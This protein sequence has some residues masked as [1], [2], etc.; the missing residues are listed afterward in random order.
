MRKISFVFFVA[1]AALLLLFSCSSETSD[2][3]G[4]VEEDIVPRIPVSQPV[5]ILRPDS[6]DDETVKAAILIR[7][8]FTDKGIDIDLYTDFVKRGEEVP[9]ADHEIVVG[10]TNRSES[11]SNYE[12]LK[13]ARSCSDLDWSIIEKDGSVYITG[14]TG[15][16][17]YAA[18]EYFSNNYFNQNGLDMLSA[19]KY[20]YEY[21]YITV[22]DNPLCNFSVECSDEVLLGETRN[23]LINHVTDKAGVSLPDDSSSKIILKTD[24]SLEKDS[25]NITSSADSVILSG[26]SFES[27]KLAAYRFLE[28]LNDKGDIQAMNITEKNSFHIPM[29]SVPKAA[30]SYTSIGDPIYLIEDGKNVLSGWD[31]SFPEEYYENAASLSSSPSA[32]IRLTNENTGKKAWMERRFNAQNSGVITLEL[33][34]SFKQADGFIMELRDDSKCAVRFTVSHGV[35]FADSSEVC[36]VSP[37]LILRADF[38][39]DK[40][41][42]TV[43]INGDIIGTYDF[44]EKINT[45][46]SLYFELKET[47]S[48]VLTPDFIYLYKNVI[49]SERFRTTVAGKAPVYYK[50]AGD[51]AVA[52]DHDVK[53]GAS[54]SLTKEFT[55]FNGKAVFQTKLLA[56]DTL[57]KTKLT[58]F[59]G[60]KAV[61]TLD[62]AA[63]KVFH[64]DD[65]L[66][67]FD[68]CFWYTVRIEP[69]TRNCFAEVKINGKSLGYFVFDEKA[70]NYDS[71]AVSTGE[72]DCVLVDDM[73]IYQLNEYDD[74]VPAPLS[75]GSG[76]S[77]V[78]CQVCSLWRNGYHWAWDCIT[79]YNELKPVLG[80]YDEGIVEVADWE[81]KY[82][83]EHG[84]DYQLYCWYNTSVSAPIKTCNMDQALHDGYFNAK[85]SDKI[86]FAIMW[87]NANATHP[88]S[89]ENFRN[90]IV[91][92]WVEY[93]LTDPRYITI[94]NKPVIT[95]FSYND[96]LKDFGSAEGVK[97]EFD[98]LRDVCRGLGYDGAIIMVQYA[99]YGQEAINTILSFGTDAT[100]AYN[101]GKTNTSEGYAKN[102]MGQYKAGINAVPTISVG[103]NNVA[104]A[105]TRSELIEL[106]DYKVA[107]SWAK[108]TFTK[109]YSDDSWLSKA[110]IISTWNEYGEGTYIMPSGLHGFGYLDAIHDVYA[111]NNKYE[112]IVPTDAQKSRLSTLYVQDRKLLRADYRVDNTVDFSECESI[113]S[114]DFTTGSNRWKE[115]F[116]LSEF[117]TGNGSLKGF[118]KASDYSVMS[119]DNLGIN[120]NNSAAI[121]ITFKCDTDGVLEIFFITDA[122]SN[123]AQGQSFNAAFK[124]SDEFITIYLPT[125][126]NAAFKGTLKQLRVD[127][128][129]V[130]SSFEIQ[131]IE[132]YRFGKIYSVQKDAKTFSFGKYKPYTNEKGTIM[133]PFDPKGAL[134]T[135]MGCEWSWKASAQEL[136]IRHGADTLILTAYSDTAVFN[137]TEIKLADKVEMYDGMPSF[138]FDEVSSILKI[139]AKLVH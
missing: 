107:L 65:I 23:L 82:M 32:R 95:V 109:N 119:K 12:S 93:Y 133:V 87:E 2:K 138:D 110:V 123:W 6:A 48:N 55:P 43:C 56:C 34:L 111:P 86:K 36:N 72:G 124:K 68:K 38:D 61:F 121:R 41:N 139:N 99:G 80:Y 50:T 35:F 33:Q 44:C 5:G 77:Y 53:I 11:I 76:G 127:P 113:V 125:S 101:W 132:L 31:Y 57:N 4:I 9:A 115:G 122:A 98:Y 29:T 129:N 42:Y 15:S 22:C 46:S 83:A 103:F 116:G 67:M 3:A 62:F 1:A 40:N 105:G 52:D 118:S 20:I 13:N 100:Y 112:D 7:K 45:L 126:T 84:I 63:S 74:Y 39:L 136:T 70:D 91:P 66:R 90:V 78:G 10:L 135:F 60:E 79:P 85:Y 114:W 102:I 88:G 21:P 8:A 97:V 17:V 96:L 64:G 49:A 18:A 120:I 130:A 58:V 73:Y 94:D 30:G 47:C 59:S 26:G 104:W 25:W 92:Y 81:I 134:L 137:G 24:N 51:V 117:K 54:S 19:E 28:I 69:D 14:I 75:A 71:F 128:N 89:S 27:A 16:A 106:D 108:D 131:S 37:T